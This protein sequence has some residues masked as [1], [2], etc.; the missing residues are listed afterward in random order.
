M[1]HCL[2]HGING[3]R[4]AHGGR[5][6]LAETIG[7]ARGARGAHGGRVKLAETIGGARGA[8]GMSKPADT[9]DGARG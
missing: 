5:V 2:V 9:R 4:R 8:R 6:K 1:R 3:A 7:G